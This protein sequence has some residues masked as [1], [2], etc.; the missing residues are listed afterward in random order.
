MLEG[1][2]TGI[3][4]VVVDAHGE[5]R[6]VGSPNANSRVLEAQ[7]L[8]A[9]STI[10][11]ADLLY[12][13]LEIPID[14]VNRVLRTAAGRD[15]P[16]LLD[17]TPLPTAEGLEDL[18][19]TLIGRADVLLTNFSSAQRLA[20]R[21]GAVGPNALEM[22]EVLLSRGPKAVIITMGQHGVMAAVAGR[23]AFVPAFADVSVDASSAGD[24]F[25]GGLAVGL[26]NQARNNWRWEEILFAVRFASAAAAI[27]VQRK[28]SVTSLPNREEVERF[29]PTS[30]VFRYCPLLK[31]IIM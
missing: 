27:C 22:A 21:K 4:E 23:H 10:F 15:V 12:A 9:D 29:W 30:P 26:T 31:G 3:H 20:G 2:P 8:K 24:A 18:D 6:V 17:A 1:V 19:D 7:A 16:V 5:R 14:T 25:G 11:G 28:G 13:T